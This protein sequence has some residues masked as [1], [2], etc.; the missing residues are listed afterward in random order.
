M[1]ALR[2]AA[3]KI[4][5][6]PENGS[7]APTANRDGT[8]HRRNKKPLGSASTLDRY[9]PASASSTGKKPGQQ[10]DVH[11]L[12]RLWPRQLRRLHKRRHGSEKLS[13]DDTGRRDAAIMLDILVQGPDGHSEATA[14]LDQSCPWMAPA[15]R[16]DAIDRAF[17]GRKFWSP[18]TLGDALGLTWKEHDD[19]EI[20]A[21]RPAGATDA[22]M[23]AVRKMKNTAAKREARRQETPAPKK[24]PL[25]AIRAKLIADLLKPGERCTVKDLCAKKKRLGLARLKGKSLTDAVHRAIARGIAQGLLRKDVVA[26]HAGYL[27]VAWITKVQPETQ[28]ADTKNLSIE[29]PCPQVRVSIIEE[30]LPASGA[31]APLS[32]D[33]DWFTGEWD[34]PDPGGRVALSAPPAATKTVINLPASTKTVLNRKEGNR[35]CFYREATGNRPGSICRGGRT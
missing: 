15:E 6:P 26:E 12:V 16:A 29:K 14:F 10:K 20:T 24:E 3:F 25:P 31:A 8:D 32:E 5:G 13:D 23:A 19:C 27:A 21:I 35:L 18:A 22:E 30:G 33:E 17:R 34:G 2:G 4:E 7:A 11:R 28:A 9:E 1:N